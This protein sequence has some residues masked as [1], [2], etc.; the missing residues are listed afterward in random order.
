MCNTEVIPYVK[1]IEQ[2]N[3]PHFQQLIC[4]NANAFFMLP[5]VISTMMFFKKIKDITIKIQSWVDIPI[6]NKGMQFYYVLLWWYDLTHV[7]SLENL[8]E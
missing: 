3:M 2:R 8:G 7:N 4:K 5:F 6:A 1:D